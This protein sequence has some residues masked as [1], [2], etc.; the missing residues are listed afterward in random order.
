MQTK[1]IVTIILVVC[2]L[3]TPIIAS[4]LNR[5][6]TVP[7]QTLT[8]ING[9]QLTLSEFKGKALLVSFWAT[10]CAA[11]IAEIPH[12]K[13]LYHDYH[14][15]GLEIVAIAM[16]YDPPNHVVA[17]SKAQQLPYHV[18]L[19]ILGVHQKAFGNVRATP[20]TYL[21]SP[22]GLVVSGIIG[23]FDLETMQRKIEQFI[24]TQ[25]FSG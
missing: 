15:Q 22:E 10:D 14:D 18:A 24:N 17:M 21:V 12:L 4:L 9:E 11:C 23:S 5:N 2:L 13:S 8:T 20:T 3:L 16:P 6:F 7:D 25:P 1:S 19:D